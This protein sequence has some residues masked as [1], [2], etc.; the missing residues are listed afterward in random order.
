MRKFPT[1]WCTV[2]YFL[3]DDFEITDLVYKA[4]Q[5]IESVNLTHEVKELRMVT[6][7][8]RTLHDMVCYREPIAL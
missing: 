6:Y 5:K 4:F 2:G 3:R 1:V 7:H 8:Q